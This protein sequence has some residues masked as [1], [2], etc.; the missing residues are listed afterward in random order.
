MNSEKMARSCCSS[1]AFVPGVTWELLHCGKQRR[2]H[3][4]DT[5]LACKRAHAHFSRAHL[6]RD[7]CTCGSRPR[8]SRLSSVARFSKQR[9]HTIMSLL[10]VSVSHFPMV[11]SSPT[12]SLS[13]PSASSTP[14]AGTRGHTCISPRWSGMSGC[15]PNPTPDT[16]YEHKFCVD[17]NDEH[18][19]INLPDSNR[20]FP[21]DCNT[22]VVV[23][24]EEADV[25]RHSGA[26]SSSKH[27]AATSRVPSVWVTWRSPL[28]TVGGL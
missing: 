24:S 19:P 4:V 10:S 27:T 12:G 17:T 5:T 6:T 21:H 1:S 14:S 18:T 7:D 13:R 15:I 3:R 23:T 2:R 8:G 16:G 26:S 20:I 22:T 28:E 11:T 25:P 9:H